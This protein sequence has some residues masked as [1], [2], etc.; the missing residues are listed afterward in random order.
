MMSGSNCDEHAHPHH[1]VAA[2]CVAPSDRAL[3]VEASLGRKVMIAV[4]VAG[5]MLLG[6]ILTEGEQLIS[7]HFLGILSAT[8]AVVRCY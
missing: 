4:S 3:A 6:A 8:A 7:H 1:S 2:L 5:G